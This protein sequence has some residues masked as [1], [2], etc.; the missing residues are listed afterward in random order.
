MVGPYLALPEAWPSWARQGFDLHG[1]NLDYRLFVWV[2]HAINGS[3][4]TNPLLIPE[5]R[6][7]IS[8]NDHAGLTDIMTELHPASI[9]EFAEG[10]LV[11]EAWALLSHGSVQR[12]AEV[13]PYFSQEKELEL[14]EGIGKDQMLKLLEAMSHDDR[15]DLL[16][17]CDQGTVESLLPLMAQA[18][19]EDIRRLLTFPENQAGSVMTT[20]YATLPP[21]ILV[22]EALNHLRL[23]APDKETIYYV[24]V[25]DQERKLIGFVSLR[26]LV[27]AKP[28]EVIREI[29]TEE[30]VSVRANQDQEEVAR[31]LAKYGFLAIPVVDDENHI[32]GI[33]TYDDVIEVLDEEAAEDIARQGASEPLGKAY[34]SVSILNL[35]RSR[36]IWLF[37]LAIAATLTVNVLSVFEAT[38]EKVVTLSLFIPLLIGVGG[39]AGAQSATTVVRGLATEE[40]LSNDLFRVVFREVRVGF[41][42]GST[43]AV[44]AF[45]VVWLIFDVQMALILSTSLVGVCTLASFVGAS[46][47]ILANYVGVDPAVVSAPFVT[48]IVD[49]TGLILYFCI[50]RA[51]LHI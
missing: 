49:T 43:L 37:M 2:R 17:R 12:Q 32:I 9:A 31:E 40:I 3:H 24:Y 27:L 22:T 41:L 21:D 7:L 48:T 20:D 19:R 6:Q 29:M 42:L 25:I 16:K 38:L 46:M 44:F 1:V 26:D 34:F 39:N 35:L 51:V 4:M 50:A 18:E 13:F 45:L 36:V 8:E 11:E 33:V 23:Q 14:I 47:P 5:I 28:T 15:V 10:L 30:I